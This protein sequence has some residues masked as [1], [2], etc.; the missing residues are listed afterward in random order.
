MARRTTGWPVGTGGRLRVARI[1]AARDAT[2]LFLERGFDRVCVLDVAERAGCSRATLYRYVGGKPAI[3]AAVVSSAQRR[4]AG[5]G[6]AVAHL[7][8]ADRVFEAILTSVA[9]VRADPALSYWFAHNRTGAANGYLASSP[10][11][12]RFANDAHRC[13]GDDLAGEWIV[14]GGPHAVGVAGSRR[15][16]GTT[17]GAALVAPAFAT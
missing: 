7:D 11:L 3:V 12:A 9:A 8:G 16:H 5:R 1:T 6:V 14:R 4:S 10:D 17:Y 15:R 13:R 2:D